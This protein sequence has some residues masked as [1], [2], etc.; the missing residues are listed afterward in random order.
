MDD[1]ATNLAAE[2]AERNGLTGPVAH[3]GTHGTNGSDRAADPAAP[4]AAPTPAALPTRRD[5]VSD[6]KAGRAELGAFLRSRRERLTPE[7]LGLAPGP[8]R[9][10]PGLRREEVAQHSGV[11]VTWY[12]WLEQG[13][14][15][16]ASAQV[17]D[18]VAR[19]LRLDATEQLHLYRLAGLRGPVLDDCAR[20]VEPE[21]QKILDALVPLP[22]CVYNG[23]YDTL[24]WNAGYASLFP[25]VVEV[26]PDERNALWQMFT[27][28]RCCCPFV[29]R[30]EETARM[31]AT[32]RGS[33]A[34]HVGDPVWTAFIR[35]LSDASPEFARMWAGHDVAEP[36]HRLKL[37][38]HPS[39]GEIRVMVTSMA[40][41]SGADIR[42]HVYSA[43]DETD[44]AGLD[45]LLAEGPIRCTHE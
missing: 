38:R 6:P 27:A 21:I 43:V 14:P 32:L 8:R 30:D 15:I 24:A 9:R 20:Q 25:K 19:T 1:V 17:L 3:L 13:R 26:P 12:T 11:S 37:F 42:M 41:A 29:N 16:N 31:V 34:R 39:M 33:F 10:T 23:R 5:G 40:L 4:A 2:T 35:R 22:A 45:R 36:G 7:D 28:P 18:A 44:Q